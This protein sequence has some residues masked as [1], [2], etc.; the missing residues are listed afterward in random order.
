MHSVDYGYWILAFPR[1]RNLLWVKFGA[2]EMVDEPKT[3]AYGFNTWN[4]AKDT[5]LF[6]DVYGHKE[7]N[8][9]LLRADIILLLQEIHYF[10]LEGLP[11]SCYL[12]YEML[13][14]YHEMTSV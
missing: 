11:W 13:E 4:C 2:L 7:S 10:F 8:N 6:A 5:D 3:S 9:E 14:T 12:Y 1:W